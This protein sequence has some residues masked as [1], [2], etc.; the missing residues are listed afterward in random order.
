MPEMVKCSGVECFDYMLDL[1]QVMG[2]EQ[3]VAR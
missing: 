1:F 3:R 2:K